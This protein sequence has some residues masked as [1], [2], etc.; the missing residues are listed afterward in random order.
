MGGVYQVGAIWSD[1]ATKTGWTIG[2]GI[3]NA[4]WANWT[5]KIEYL[6]VDLGSITANATG[7][8][9]TFGGF[10]GNCY[11]AIGGTFCIAAHG[12]PQGG[13]TSKFTDNIVRVGLNYQFH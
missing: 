7:G 9:G 11:G 10:S 3:E 13:V 8:L 1:S 5:W 4:I 6:Y 12:T 2:A